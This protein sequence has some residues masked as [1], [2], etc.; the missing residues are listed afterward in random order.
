MKHDGRRQRH[1]SAV[2]WSIETCSRAEV[3]LSKPDPV[4]RGGTIRSKVEVRIGKTFGKGA[5]FIEVARQIHNMA[6]NFKFT[7]H[8]LW[9]V[10]HH[11]SNQ[12]NRAPFCVL[13]ALPSR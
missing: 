8:N 9:Y 6:L 13:K 1:V 3:A 11:G 12:S 10:D 7:P 5:G 2:P 4:A